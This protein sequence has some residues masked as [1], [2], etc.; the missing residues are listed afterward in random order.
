MN[1]QIG[2]IDPALFVPW[3]P[4]RCQNCAESIKICLRDHP[5]AFTEI[6]YTTTP[7]T[8]NARLRSSLTPKTLP[9]AYTDANGIQHV[10]TEVKPRPD[11]IPSRIG[12]FYRYTINGTAV[13]YPRDIWPVNAPDGLIALDYSIDLQGPRKPAIPLNPLEHRLSYPEERVKKP[14]LHKNGESFPNQNNLI[15]N[16]F[17]QL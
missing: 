11:L 12:I 1:L 3:Y 16:P 4:V 15:R 2:Q 14:G 17:R 13:A 5:D 10:S 8:F 9:Y 7:P 6:D